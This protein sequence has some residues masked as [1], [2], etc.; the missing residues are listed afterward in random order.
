MRYHFYVPCSRMVQTEGLLEEAHG[1]SISERCTRERQE[2]PG[3][4]RRDLPPKAAW[5][6]LAGGYRWA[7]GPVSIARP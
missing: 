6:S 2:E 4:R 7:P 1:A 5:R 3:R